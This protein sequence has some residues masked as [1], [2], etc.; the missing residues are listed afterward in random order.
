MKYKECHLYFN[1]MTRIDFH[2]NTKKTIYLTATPARSQKEEDIIYQEYFRNVPAIELFDPETDP[3]VNYVGMLFY[4]NPS[5]ADVR[6]FS[7]GQFQFDRNIYMG[8]LTPRPNFL[9][10]T[11]IL[12]DMT[13]R[14]PGKVLIYVGINESIEYIRQHIINEFPFLER[15][16]GIYTSVVQDKELRREMLMKKFILSTTKSCGAASDIPDLSACIVLNEPFRS[17]V[18]ARQTLGRCRNDNT[19]YIDC[20]DMSCYR[21]KLYYQSKKPVFN[22]YAKSCSEVMMT[23]DMIDKKYDEVKEYWNTHKLLTIPAFTR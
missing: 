7:V 15:A 5:P 13:L 9:K 17:K 14:I 21:T 12:I 16:I 3:H 4:S 20:V 10:L 11:T 2:T 22:Q 1:N 19:L 8:Y 6:R 18:T 23:N